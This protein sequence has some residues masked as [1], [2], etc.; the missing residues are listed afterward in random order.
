[1]ATAYA[2]VGASTSASYVAETSFGVTPSNP[3]MTS[4]RAKLGAKFDLKRETFQSAE[5][6]ATRQVQALSYGNRSGS[7][8]IPFRTQLRQL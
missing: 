8:E 2:A 5:M 7:A 4:L 3:T 6:T 1:M